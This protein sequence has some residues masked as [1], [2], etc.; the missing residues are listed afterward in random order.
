ML[1][2]NR[3]LDVEKTTLINAQKYHPLSSTR[4]RAHCILLSAQNYKIHEI[5][6][7]CNVCRQSVSSAIYAWESEGIVG[8]MDKP[9]SG[10]P[11]ILTQEQEEVIIKQVEQSPRSLKKVLNEFSQMYD[12]NITLA[13]L[14]NICKKAGLRWK[15]VRKSLKG[16]RNEVEYQ[17]SKALINELVKSYESGEIELLYFDEA[18]F[19]LTP[20]VPYAWQPTKKYIEIPSSKSQSFNVL[21]FVNKACQ[22]ESFVFQGAINT[23]I[24]IKCCNYSP[25]NAKPQKIWHTKRQ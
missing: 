24:V 13:T 8:L 21:G 12:I 6:G 19:N 1:F 16:K 5:S 17:R 22:F 3:L 11:K 23:D 20:N 15:R 18:G 7:I 10:R 4:T 14:K 25:P 9:R 2:A